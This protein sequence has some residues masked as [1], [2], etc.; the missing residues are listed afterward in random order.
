[1]SR[2]EGENPMLSGSDDV[3][4]GASFKH[5]FALQTTEWSYFVMHPFPRNRQFC[6]SELRIEVIIMTWSFALR[7]ADEL[8]KK[9]G[10][11]LILRALRIWPTVLS[12]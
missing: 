2:D 9:M 8:M 3:D 1:V 6:T 12:F 5:D 7:R 4:I 11:K 10:H